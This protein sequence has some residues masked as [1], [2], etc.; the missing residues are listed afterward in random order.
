MTHKGSGYSSYLMRN[1]KKRKKTFP[2]L[3]LIHRRSSTHVTDILFFKLNLWTFH[4][5]I[6]FIVGIVTPSPL[7]APHSTE[8]DN[9]TEPTTTSLCQRERERRFTS[10]ILHEGKI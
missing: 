8:K 4:F 7:P 1:K 2:F 5:S 3:I 10:I 6:I 9:V